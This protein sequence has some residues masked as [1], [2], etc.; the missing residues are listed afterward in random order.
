MATSVDYKKQVE[1]LLEVLPFIQE[2]PRLALKGG[3]AI[4]LF[5]RSM[6]RLSVDIDLTYLPIEP[7][8]E[9]LSN[10]TQAMGNLAKKLKK[11]RLDVEIRY[12]AG[13]IIKLLV[14]NKL[15]TIKVEPNTILRGS[16]FEPVVKELSEYAQ[17]EFLQTQKVKMLSTGDLYAGK[18]CAALDR[19]HPR[20]LFDIRLLFDSAFLAHI[21]HCHHYCQS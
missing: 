10:L 9:F 20:D 15:S 16:V 14:S 8:E 3:T 2:Q 7:R 6:P 18:I 13:H 12:S 19:Q 4:N 21:L 1:L 17:N 5:H 11:E